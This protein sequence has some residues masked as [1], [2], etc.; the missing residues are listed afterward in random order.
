MKRLVKLV[1]L[2]SFGIAR[3][4]SAAC[5][6]LNQTDMDALNEQGNT[7]SEQVQANVLFQNA[8][9]SIDPGLPVGSLIATGLSTA[10]PTPIFFV[11]CVNS[12]TLTLNVVGATPSNLPGIYNTNVPG[13][14][15][16]LSQLSAT[17]A[18]T[19]YP[20]VRTAQPGTED[21]NQ[22]VYISF[23]AGTQFRIELYKTGDIA[24]NVNVQFGLVGTG[25]G[26]GD[27]K[28]IVMI[29]GSS[30]NIKVLPTCTVN[31]SAL[32]IDFGTFG[33]ADVST[34]AGPTRAVEFTVLCSGPTPPA[35]ITAAL[36]GTPDTDDASMLK[37]TG[38][39]NLA[40][41]L[42]DVSKG[43]ILRPN[44]PASTVVQTPGGSMQSPFSL[45]ATV[46]RV[47]SATPRAGRIQATATLT[48]TIL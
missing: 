2:I 12:G 36:S 33:P 45:E 15:F 35:S 14:G 11:A 30:L 27:G 41:R 29:N 18:A 4:A 39:T 43:T 24:S 1:I 48:M 25:H 20:I 37:N 26:D 47:G 16:K 5:F 46:L 3:I 6:Q 28:T 21:P 44:D 34:T 42:K 17:G 19:D 23:G 7:P 13:V 31:T 32:N 8:S 40:I 22:R 9:V 38:A 10:L